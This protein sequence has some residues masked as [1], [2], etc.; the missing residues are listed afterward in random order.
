MQKM[1]KPT[2]SEIEAKT[3]EFFRLSDTDNNQKISQ[4]EFIAYIKKDKQI[5]EVLMGGGIAKNEDL[6]TNFGDN[7]YDEDLH[8]EA[9]PKGLQESERK[10][11]AKQGELFEEEEADEGDQ[12]M[13]VKPFKGVVDH[14]IPDGYKPS[15]KDGQAPEAFLELEYI[16]G[17]RCHDTR[18]NLNYTADGKVCYHAAGVGVVLDQSKNKQQFMLDHNDD[19]YCMDVDSTRKYAVTG[20]NGPKPLLIV[21]DLKTMEVLFRV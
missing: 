18:N 3:E 4:K 19:I 8:Q 6:G 15:S 14:T 10:Q 11:K 13:A 5:L 20:Q 9:N 7:D 12:F 1:K 21:W 2:I 17:Y 16:H